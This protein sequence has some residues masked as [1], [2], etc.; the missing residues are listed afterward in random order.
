[1]RTLL[2]TL[3]LLFSVNVFGAGTVN[4]WHIENDTT[5]I[6]EQFSIFIK[7]SYS[8]SS[9]T[10]RIYIRHLETS[11]MI[12]VYKF[13]VIEL[14]DQT[15]TGIDGTYEILVTV[16]LNIGKCRVIGSSSTMPQVDLFVRSDIPDFEI[17]G[18]G[19]NTFSGYSGFTNSYKIRWTYKEQ[20]TDSMK[21]FL[22]GV[23]L[24][25]MAISEMLNDSI[26]PFNII[27][28][29]GVYKMT[30]NYILN[31]PLVYIDYTIISPVS[32]STINPI[33]EKEE[34]IYY[35]MQGVKIEKPTQGFYLWKSQKRS[36]KVYTEY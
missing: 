26:I 36:G 18:F 25:K 13:K 23:L 5:T 32:T 2:F 31:T 7:C 29:P 3:A 11:Q 1:M 14:L 20:P 21:L 35:N 10:G 4:I 17:S 34:I 33:E 24:K 15:P 30:G 9:D 28:N 8:N 19:S 27:G 22:D 16:P 6:G 12:Q